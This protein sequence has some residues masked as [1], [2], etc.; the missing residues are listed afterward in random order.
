MSPVKTF[1]ASILLAMLPT[2]TQA[3]TPPEVLRYYEIYQAALDANDKSK[4]LLAAKR[5]YEISEK[6]LGETETTGMLAHNYAD[7]LRTNEPD[8]AISLF[9]RAIDLTSGDGEAE[10]SLNAQRHILIGQTWIRREDFSRSDVNKMKADFRASSKFMR[11]HGLVNTTFGAEALVLDAIRLSLDGDYDV[12]VENIDQ[13]LAIFNSPSH[14]FISTLRHEAYVLKGDILTRAE[15]PIE[16]AL[17]YQ[18]VMQNLEGDLPSDHPF[19]E[20]AFHKWMYSRGMITQ[21]KMD[22]E[23]LKAGV[24]KCW[25][26]DEMSANAP[27]PKLRVPPIMPRRARRSGYVQILFDINRDGEPYN[28][29]ATTATNTMFIEP[30]IRSVK[31]WE[32]EIGEDLK[33]EDL[34]GIVSKISFRL[35]DERGRVYSEEAP[36]IIKSE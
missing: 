15:Q 35:T 18:F 22:A 23:A 11:S 9:K 16:A 29:R 6:L 34:K 32:Y 33:D 2:L 3:K 12:A 8:E 1:I 30:S 10:L 14:T 21:T 20:N 5:A 28:V 4:A 31:K 26:Y 24:C 36:K 7:L 17:S 25:P 13:A 19:I 27:L